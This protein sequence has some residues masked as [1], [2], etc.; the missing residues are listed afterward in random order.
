MS[1]LDRFLRFSIHVFGILC[2]AFFWIFLV[3]LVVMSAIGILF[4]LGWTR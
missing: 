3:I 4:F 2:L 1:W